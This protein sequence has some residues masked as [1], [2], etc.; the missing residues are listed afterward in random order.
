MKL[1]DT[2][3]APEVAEPLVKE[4]ATRI[5]LIVFS[6]GSEEYALPIDQVKEIVPTPRIS[7]V[8]QTPEYVLGIANIRGHVISIIDLEKK[9]G[10]RSVTPSEETGHRNTVYTLVIQDEHTHIGVITRK[11]P[12][13]LTVLS[14]QINDADSMMRHSAIDESAIKGVVN[15]KSRLII[16]V[17]VLQ[18]I[19]LGE[20]KTKN[21]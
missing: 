2:T 18:M 13:T 10:L 9:F 16:L 7:E 1:S 5:Q 20:L 14:S 8:P 3:I 11:V 6:L 21:S 15:V 4:D 12:N 17:D 19:A